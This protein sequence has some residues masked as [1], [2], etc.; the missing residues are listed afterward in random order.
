MNCPACSSSHVIKNGKL[1][2][3]KLKFKCK[4]CGRQ[5]VEN[6]KRHLI[7]QDTKQ[8]IDKLLLES[9]SLA[10]IARV[11]GVSER[12]LYNYLGQNLV[13]APPKAGLKKSP[14]RLTKK[15]KELN[16]VKKG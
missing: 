3:G 10:G 11:S 1:S 5:F 13:K 6:P 14:N 7:S 16:V 9:I 8:L 15:Y 12:W 2:N 4:D